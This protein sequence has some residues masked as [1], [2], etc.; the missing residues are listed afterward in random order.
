MNPSIFLL[1][2]ANEKEADAIVQRLLKKRLIVCAKRMS[3]SSAFLWEGKI[4]SDEEVLVIMESHDKLFEKVEK[5][6]RKL[7][8]YDTPVLVSLPIHYVSRGIMEWMKDELR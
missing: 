2:C 3:V 7:H 6:V 8:S 4:D 1:T 5:E